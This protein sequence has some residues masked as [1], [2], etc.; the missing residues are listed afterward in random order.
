MVGIKL[1]LAATA[2]RLVA[3]SAEPTAAARLEERGRYDCLREPECFS[4][5][6]HIGRPATQFCY[7][8]L[9]SVRTTT[10]ITTIT[11]AAV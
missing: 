9:K 2:V 7:S 3:A 1:I 5:L 10:T 11:P 8:Y 4:S 6:K